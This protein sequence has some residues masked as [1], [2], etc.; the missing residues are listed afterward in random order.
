[1]H[2]TMLI[3]DIK[4]KNMV[5]SISYVQEHTHVRKSAD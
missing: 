5:V 3:Q 4:E 2:Y 1:M